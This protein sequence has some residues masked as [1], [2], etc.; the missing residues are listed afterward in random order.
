MVKDQYVFL[1]QSVLFGTSG[2]NPTDPHLSNEKKGTLVVRL[3]SFGGLKPPSD[4][5]P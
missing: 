4:H 2:C 1:L 5:K 3:G